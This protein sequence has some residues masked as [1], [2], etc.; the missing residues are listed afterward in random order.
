MVDIEEINKKFDKNISKEFPVPDTDDIY[1]LRYIIDG[2]LDSKYKNN[3]EIR[4]ELCKIYPNDTFKS[5][6]SFIIHAY[7]KLCF[8]GIYDRNRTEKIIQKCLRI[9]KG[10]SNSGVLVITVFTSPYPEYTDEYGKI[11]KQSFSC[12]WNCAYCPNEPGQP[13]SYLKG[14]PGVLR[15]NRNQF[16]PCM[17]MWSRMESLALNGHAIDK[18]E[19]IVLGGTWTSYPKEYREEF[20]RDIYY[21]ANTFWSAFSSKPMRS[22]FD[23]EFEKAFNS[24][25]CNEG[26]IIG[27]TLETRPD[28]INREELVLLRK[29]GCTRV[30]LGIQ[31]LKQDILD[32]IRRDCTIE[33]IYTAIKLL[34]DN[35]FKVDAHFM[36][37]LPGSTPQIDKDMFMNDLL[38]TRKTVKHKIINNIEYSYYDMNNENIQVDQ[39]KVYPCAIVPWTSIETWYK[40]GEYIQYSDEDLID[41]LLDMKSIMVPWIR[42]NR[43][44]RDIPVDYIIDSSD[45]P[46]LRQDLGKILNLEGKC[47][48]C[49]R[50]REIKHTKWVEYKL[51]IDV[52]NSSGGTEY[53]ISALCKNTNLL[54]GFLRLRISLDS[55]SVFPELKKSGLIRELHVYGDINCIKN[56]DIDYSKTQHRGIGKVLIEQ[57]EKITKQY[58]LKKIAVIAG[59]GT[60]EYY[61]KRLFS[62]IDGCGRFMIKNLD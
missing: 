59:E 41:V 26:R 23:L 57:A 12:K 52:Y 13:R 18:L 2:I 11:H 10:K 4:K 61:K 37:N 48:K 3:V 44:I 17:Q 21:S 36:P 32:K 56:N 39:W 40:N 43:I 7:F 24:R 46:N 54:I 27:L 6:T 19:V 33:Q 38:G 49:I 45:V 53:F 9:K 30:Q 25:I 42:L 50:C 58:N 1:K 51:H 8:M 15:A 20:I 34:K 5:R 62:I 35:C 16:D 22:K 31:H 47:C 55:G 29:Y 14:E 60:R 28:T